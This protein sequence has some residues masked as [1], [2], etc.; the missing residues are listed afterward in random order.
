M[1][2]AT[3]AAARH[4]H[5]QPSHILPLA[6]L[7]RAG[8]AV[9]NAVMQAQEARGRRMRI[10]AL[11]AMSDAQLAQMGLRRDQINGPVRQDRAHF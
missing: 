8:R 11:M 7:R 3:H 5:D 10:E 4:E 6:A 1:T 2:T 9:A